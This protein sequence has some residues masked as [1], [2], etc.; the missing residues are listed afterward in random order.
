M[1]PSADDGVLLN[2]EY[3]IEPEGQFLSLVLESWSGGKAGSRLPRNP[4][5]NRALTHCSLALR[6]STPSWWML[7]VDSRQTAALGLPETA[8]RIVAG[9]VRLVTSEI[10]KRF[11]ARWV[12]PSPR[13]GR[14][15]MLRK[16]ET[17]QSASGSAW[18]FPGMVP[19]EPTSSPPTWPLPQARTRAPGRQLKRC[20][21]R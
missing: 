15:L 4:D 16:R 5:Y 3:H 1:Q 20:S 9:P 18:R 11:G 10:W 6:S 12:P 13:L 21:A 2:A 19:T 17:R 7:L 8:R 14:P